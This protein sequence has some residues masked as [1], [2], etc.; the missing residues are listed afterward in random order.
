MRIDTVLISAQHDPYVSI[1]TM[2]KDLYENVVKHIIPSE[3]MDENTKFLVNPTGRF[4]L[5]GPVA[6]SGLT[7]RKIIVDT[8]GG[9]A[10]HGGGAFSGKDP[11]KVD[12]T[13]AYEARHI[14]KNI[15]ASG[16][17]KRC[18]IQLSYAIGVASPISIN[19]NTFGTAKVDEKT[20]EDIITKVFD[21]RPAAMIKNLDLRKPIYLNT[22][23]Y[24]HFG[25]NDLDLTW[26]K[27]DKVDEIKALI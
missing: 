26:E 27:L 18:E 12:R 24:G 7:G 9:A 13:A 1:E 5:G 2:K 4:V 10:K 6:D 11:T 16:L 17:C 21:M 22:A 20:I 15:V 25:R 14:A 8:Y 3:L 23:S 19:V